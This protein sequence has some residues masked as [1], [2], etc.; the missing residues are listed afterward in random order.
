MLIRIVAI[1]CM[2]ALPLSAAAQASHDDMNRSNNPLTVAPG[3]NFQD[4]YTPQLYGTDAHTNDFLLRG[5]LPLL[6]G[7]TIKFPQLIRVTAPVSTRPEPGGGYTTGLGDINVFDI[8]LLGQTAS[9]IQYG[10]GPLLV[11]PTASDDILGTGKYQGGFAATVVHASP[12]GLVAGL[13]QVQGSFAGDGDRPDVATATLQPFYIRNLQGGWY[14]RSSGIWTFNL[15]NDD[16]F[17]PIGLG[18]GKVWKSGGT[19]F[20]LFAEPQWTVAHDGDG[21]PK[22]AVF[23]GLNLTLGQ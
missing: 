1:A 17:I 16:Y 15:K 18:A 7:D 6:P 5:T 13:L 23:M 9:G 21:L 19:T 10:A 12:D 11:L 22:F 8:F 20:N 2:A 4:I 3:L 14:L